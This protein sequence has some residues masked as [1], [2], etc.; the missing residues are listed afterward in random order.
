[1]NPRE[2]QLRHCAAPVREISAWFISGGEPA[3]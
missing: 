1:M 2:L 3:A